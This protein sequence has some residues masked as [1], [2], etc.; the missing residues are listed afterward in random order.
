ME[1][2]DKVNA[3]FLAQ[4]IPNDSTNS[5]HLALVSERK[6]L[7]LELEFVVEIS[8]FFDC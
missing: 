1:V 6:R 2:E 3:G 4:P 7:C 8:S 5:L